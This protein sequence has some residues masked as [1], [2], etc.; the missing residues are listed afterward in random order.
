M[1]VSVSSFATELS[2]NF[3]YMILVFHFS[4][5]SMI[6][7]ENLMI[8]HRRKQNDLLLLFSPLSEHR[9]RE[10]KLDTF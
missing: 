6:S 1:N 9:A 3:D 2:C 5:D 8:I 4:L 7:S 10:T